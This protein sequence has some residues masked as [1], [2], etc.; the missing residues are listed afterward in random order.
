VALDLH[1]RFY[2]Y[3]RHNTQI[4][5]CVELVRSGVSCEAELK[6]KPCA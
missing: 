5:Y 1:A 3:S 2:W 4:T 6:L